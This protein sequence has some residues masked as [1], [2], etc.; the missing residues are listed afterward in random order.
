MLRYHRR[1]YFSGHHRPGVHGGKSSIDDRNG[2]QDAL[3]ILVLRNIHLP[4]RTICFWTSPIYEVEKEWVLCCWC[5]VSSL[6][7]NALLRCFSLKPRDIPAFIYCW[8]IC[9]GIKQVDCNAPCVSVVDSEFT[10]QTQDYP[11]ALESGYT[12][13]RARVEVP[14]ST[15]LKIGIVAKMVILQQ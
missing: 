7:G 10:A 8:W 13:P 3:K 5:K 4:S 11:D 9:L 1:V 2:V 14:L 12:P 6:P 15:E